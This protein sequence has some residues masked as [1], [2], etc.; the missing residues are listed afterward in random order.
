[1]VSTSRHSLVGVAIDERQSVAGELLHLRDP[2][3]HV[4]LHR[5]V[6]HV[7]EAVRTGLLVGECGAHPRLHVAHLEQERVGAGAGGSYL[8]H[9]LQRAADFVDGVVQVRE[10]VVERGGGARV[11]G[12]VGVAREVGDVG[13]G[14]VDL[15]EA[16]GDGDASELAGVLLDR[17]GVPS[18]GGVAHVGVQRGVAARADEGGVSVAGVDRGLG[19]VSCG[20][21]RVEVGECG[22]EEE[23]GEEEKMRPLGSHG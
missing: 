19:C 11:A 21:G 17:I 20:G 16:D 23:E 5:T 12:V 8:P 10:A 22:C 14:A 9:L 6:R 1:M 18:E 15:R 13:G 7:L 2:V 3:A 4:R